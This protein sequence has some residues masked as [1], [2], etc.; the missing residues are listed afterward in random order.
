[1]SSS[2]SLSDPESQLDGSATE[3]SHPGVDA[4][5]DGEGG[6]GSQAESTEDAE[7]DTDSEDQSGAQSKTGNE[8]T[9]NAQQPPT[10][11]PAGSPWS[12]GSDFEREYIDLP[13]VQP[14]RR[15]R[16]RSQAEAFSQ[17]RVV[18]Q[19]A[20]TGRYLITNSK[21]G[22]IEIRPAAYIT[23]DSDFPHG[24]VEE[25]DPHADDPILCIVYGRSGRG[26]CGDRAIHIRYPGDGRL[27]YIPLG[28]IIIEREV[29][30][31][32][33]PTYP[34][35]M[36]VGHDAPGP[37]T[38][39]VRGISS[40]RLGIEE[41]MFGKIWTS[42]GGDPRV[43]LDLPPAQRHPIVNF[44]DDDDGELRYHDKHYWV[45]APLDHPLKCTI[46]TKH[47][48]EPQEVDLARILRAT[49]SNFLADAI[50]TMRRNDCAW[51]EGGLGRR[52][53]FLDIRIASLHLQGLSK[54]RS[55]QPPRSVHA[56]GRGQVATPE[57]AQLFSLCQAIQPIIT[58]GEVRIARA[59]SAATRCVPIPTAMT[60]KRKALP[61]PVPENAKRLNNRTIPNASAASAARAKPAATAEVSRET[62]A[63]RPSGAAAQAPP[64]TQ[65]ASQ[66]QPHV[67][68]RVEARAQK[69]SQAAS[70]VQPQ[71][72]V[73]APSKVRPSATSQPKA[74]HKAPATSPLKVPGIPR[75]GVS[76]IISVL[77]MT[78]QPPPS[79]SSA[80]S[81]SSSAPSSPSPAAAQGRGGARPQMQAQTQGYP[82]GSG[83]APARVEDA[84]EA[85]ADAEVGASVSPGNS[86]GTLA[87]VPASRQRLVQIR[88]SEKASSAAPLSPSSTT[89][90]EHSAAHPTSA[91]A[92]PASSISTSDSLSARIATP[93]ASQRRHF[94]NQAPASPQARD[95]SQSRG[96]VPIRETE[97]ASAGL[98][99]S[100][101]RKVRRRRTLQRIGYALL[102]LDDM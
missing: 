86:D 37:C 73:P 102:W 71:S 95:P 45:C 17:P 3:D 51:E 7:G 75:S 23:C 13:V 101:R 53:W 50:V 48:G 65:I 78:L 98:S 21:T 41:N 54:A 52:Q 14:H 10:G 15:V 79:G 31:G 2:S 87:P 8:K 83:L 81:E 60:G 19:R 69:P 59:P 90:H 27:P 24:E 97:S 89:A 68:E 49:N 61:A 22:D 26:P 46:L 28:D 96:G 29:E 5:E 56:V 4:E 93:R 64:L 18:S 11:S 76:P 20:P 32:L 36:F 57:L 43:C 33:D 44:E 9:S 99:I 100:T 84:A 30:P 38:S 40:V 63:Q 67:Q 80:S 85:E 39:F 6:S 70:Q 55:A 35:L 74:K 88:G 72:Q 16:F 66:G 58:S 82:A 94:H 91:V 62:P 12:P 34:H 92:S 25:D 1:M 77:D 42:V 47:G